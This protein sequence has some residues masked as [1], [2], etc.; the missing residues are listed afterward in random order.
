MNKSI[1]SVF[2]LLLAALAFMAFAAPT[3]KDINPPQ[4]KTAALFPEDIQKIMETS[5]YDCHTA[6]S[7]GE[8]AKMKLNFSKWSEMTSAK[9]VGKLEGI[10]EVI[11][12][13]DMPPAKYLA[14]FPDKAL[15]TEQKEQVTKWI[16]E[17][18]SK[19]MGE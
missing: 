8:K 18:S 16:A 5:C 9:K 2:L 3:G 15:T 17:E 10:T 6:A 7:T 1:T 13:G 11:T 19:L 4:D 14:K 12:S